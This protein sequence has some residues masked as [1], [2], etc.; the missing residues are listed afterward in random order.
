VKV[1][2]RHAV[3]ALAL[4]VAVASGVNAAYGGSSRSTAAVREVAIPAR[5]FAPGRIQVLLGDTV[6]WRNGDGTNHTVTSDDDLFDSGFIAPGL[7]FAR[8]F[9]KVGTFKYHCTI[10]K[11]MRGEVVVVPVALTAPAEPVVSGGR[12]VLQG[13]APSGTARVAVQ[14]L[15]TGGKVVGRVVPAGDG[16]FTLALRV[17]APADFNAVAKGRLSPHVHVA[18]EPKVI[19]RRN[20]GTVSVVARPR[21]AGAHA[22]LQR[23][24]RE[25]FDWRDVTEG[26]LDARSRVTFTL[27]KEPGRFRVVV[28][29]GDGWA[30]GASPTVV[31]KR[32]PA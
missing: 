30:D 7:T 17:F 1:S 18:V 25:L 10:H 22:V 19:V 14:R 32:S 5:V 13:F 21:R 27:P 16:S 9:A 3:V 26:R 31:V 6:V 28:R 29:G 23:Y 2:A 8:A 12:I 15:G 4:A 11:T 20:G 24:V